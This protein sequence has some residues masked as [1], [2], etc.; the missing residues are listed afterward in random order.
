MSLKL[1][2]GEPGQSNV[3]SKYFT[4]PIQCLGYFNKGI[5]IQLEK[6]VKLHKQLLSW[7]INEF[8][9]S[10]VND[11][12]NTINANPNNC[13]KWKS[14][15]QQEIKKCG[16]LVNHLLDCMLTLVQDS[17]R[18]TVLDKQA[19]SKDLGAE[20][21]GVASHQSLG[22]NGPITSEEQPTNKDVGAENDGTGFGGKSQPI[23]R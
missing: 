15:W 3:L 5:S 14:S 22:Q 17:P 10:F 20:Y 12:T 18:S 1:S 6:F 7:W 9:P 2:I 19:I 13:T 4:F 11:I 8:I 23:L 21:D 16:C